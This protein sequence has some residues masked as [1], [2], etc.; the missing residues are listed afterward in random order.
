MMFL[1]KYFRLL[2]LF[3]IFNM[4][5]I[6]SAFSRG[7]GYPGQELL[8]TWRVVRNDLSEF[9]QPVS[10]EVMN[11]LVDQPYFL[12]VGQLIE[13]TFDGIY[14]TSGS[15]RGGTD[16]NPHPKVPQLIFRTIPPL[17]QSLCKFGVW[18]R[19]ICENGIMPPAEEVKGFLSVFVVPKNEKQTRPR[20]VKWPDA[21][22]Y[23]YFLWG[24]QTRFNIRILK[25]NRLLFMFIGG[26][27][28]AAYETAG[29]VYSVWEKVSPTGVKK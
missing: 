10:Q 9:P 25:G 1:S 26:P 14:E 21:S 12:P 15:V 3:F 19:A 4:L 16:E 18:K 22:V 7:F 2:F 13:V 5:E 11:G 24:E 6:N 23:E 27:E 17:S 20:L 28:P 8:G 29:T